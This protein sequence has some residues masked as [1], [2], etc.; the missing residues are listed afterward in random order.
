MDRARKFAQEE[1]VAARRDLECP[2]WILALGGLKAELG[3]RTCFDAF[4]FAEWRMHQSIQGLVA[5]TLAAQLEGCAE[6]NLR[7]LAWLVRVVR[8]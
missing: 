1:K 2:E 5:P 4:D 8:A 6:Q 3:I 7:N